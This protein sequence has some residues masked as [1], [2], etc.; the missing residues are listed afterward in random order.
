MAMGQELW[1]H[2][3]MIVGAPGILMSH[4]LSFV[5]SQWGIFASST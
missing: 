5:K 4:C 1:P 3:R 2:R